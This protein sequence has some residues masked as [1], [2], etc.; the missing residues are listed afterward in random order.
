[1]NHVSIDN[2]DRIVIND[3]NYVFDSIRSNYNSLNPK[4]IL[5]KCCPRQIQ[6]QQKEKQLGKR[7]RGCRGGS[8][9][10]RR[11]DTAGN[12]HD[13]HDDGPAA[14]TFKME[15]KTD[16][17][18]PNRSHNKLLVGQKIMRT[19]MDAATRI[20]LQGEGEYLSQ[21]RDFENSK[22]ENIPSDTIC[23]DSVNTKSSCSTQGN[24]GNHI[25]DRVFYTKVLYL[26]SLFIL[27]QMSY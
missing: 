27:H 12:V 7:R 9:K 15:T 18:Q 8:R 25:T 13:G 20:S 19:F 10:K 16:I 26:K 5:D 17:S 23:P 11:I 4:A 6:N 3:L 21:S 14:S 24:Y 2:V 22:V 1:M